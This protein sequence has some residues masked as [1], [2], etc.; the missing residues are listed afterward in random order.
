MDSSLREELK[1]LR[2]LLRI[3]REINQTRDLHS[4]LRLLARE[5]SSVINAE[6]ST[7]FLHDPDTDELWS[8]VA[9]GEKDQ[10]R[11]GV[12]TGMAGFVFR[13]GETLLIPDVMEDTRFNPAIDQKTGFRT[14]SALTVPIV[15]PDGRTLGS[16][17]VV[18]K[19]RGEF[20]DQD[21]EFLEAIA[22]EA[23]ISIENV[24]LYESRK[25][26]FDSLID[27]LAESI[28]SR[29]PLTAGHSENVMR[30]AVAI[31]EELGLPGSERETIKYAAL[32][33]DYGKIGI[34]DS[35]LRK[36]GPERLT[37]EEYTIIKKHVEYTHNIL[38][39][40]D[41]E[42]GLRL[43][44]LYATQHHER[45]SGDGYPE[46]LVLDQISIGGRIIAVADVYEALT[47]ERHYRSPLEPGAA[48]RILVEGIGTSF[49]ADPVLALGRHLVEEGAISAADLPGRRSPGI[50]PQ[51]GPDLPVQQ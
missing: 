4:L 23:A 45:A 39:R 40:I 47:S 10:I 18:N 7:V 43:V 24:Q 38:S 22:N 44:P 11:I 14:R 21:A 33:H 51:A 34:P 9:E 20:D 27:A 17:Q 12:G 26:M 29:D 28:E 30:Y 50:D 8:I 16:F 6:R 37:P 25:R 13:S 31:A 42:E 2:S 36:P 48:Y 5:T 32:L 46:G 41:F 49:D 1:K 19:L 35:V 3:L 15:N